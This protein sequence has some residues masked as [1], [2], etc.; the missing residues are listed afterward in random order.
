MIALVC[1]Y[2]CGV[3]FENLKSGLSKPIYMN[4]RS[5]IIKLKENKI[6]INDSYNANP[7]SMEMAIKTLD[8]INNGK[9]SMAILGDMLELGKHAVSKHYEIGE[10]L[11]K[12]RIECVIAIGQYAEY[13]G[14]GIGKNIISRICG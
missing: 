3:D 5:E 9:K 10:L 13:I 2:L 1:G 8:E 4:A 14:Q 12:S 11:V 7:L 6:L